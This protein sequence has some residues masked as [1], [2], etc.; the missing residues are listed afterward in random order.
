[1]TEIPRHKCMVYDGPANWALRPVALA[2]RKQLLKNYRCIYLNS[3]QMVAAFLS[4]LR[5][6]GVEV[7]AEIRRGRLVASSAR[8][9]LIDGRFE[10]DAMLDSLNTEYDRSI[11]DGFAGLW[12]TGDM[13]WEMGPDQDVTKLLK[14][15]WGLESFINAHPRFGGI[16]QYNRNTLPAGLVERASGAHRAI[17]VNETLSMLNAQFTPLGQ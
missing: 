4:S 6:E 1:M 5:A 10:I 16:C 9:H 13:T 17:F 14:Y 11:R 15:E 12:A 7:D 3:E 8:P 2:L